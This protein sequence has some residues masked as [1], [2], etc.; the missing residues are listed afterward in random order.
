ML[1]V[2]TLNQ[3]QT[4]PVARVLLL[5][6]LKSSDVMQTAEIEHVMLFTSLNLIDVRQLKLYVSYCLLH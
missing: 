1:V 4:I 2:T 5:T 3:R 6:S